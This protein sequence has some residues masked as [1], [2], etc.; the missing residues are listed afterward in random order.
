MFSIVEDPL[1]LVV[2]VLA[3]R[4]EDATDG[5]LDLHDDEDDDHHEDGDAPLNSRHGSH[6]E[7][8]Y[9]FPGT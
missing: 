7:S 5:L 3:L 2:R 6:A 9:L 1:L 4:L 8:V